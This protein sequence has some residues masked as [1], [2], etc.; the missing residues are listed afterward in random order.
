MNFPGLAFT[1]ISGDLQQEIQYVRAT[2]ISPVLYRAA[3][4]SIRTTKTGSCWARRKLSGRKNTQTCGFETTFTPDSEHHGIQR[5]TA[6]ERGPLSAF[7]FVRF[8]LRDARRPRFSSMETSAVNT[9]APLS[10]DYT[11]KHIVV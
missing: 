4:L 1:A 2:C 5:Y 7:S 10:N 3:A 8:H 9:C 6:V 11:R